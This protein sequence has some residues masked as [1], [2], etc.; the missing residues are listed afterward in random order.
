MTSFRLC[1]RDVFA[2]KPHTEYHVLFG[3]DKPE[4]EQEP[5]AFFPAHLTWLATSMNI[6]CEHMAPTP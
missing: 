6:I 3:P 5:F 2:T 4:L 1:T